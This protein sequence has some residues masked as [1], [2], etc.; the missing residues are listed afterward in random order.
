MYNTVI[1]TISG[2]Y[3]VLWTD[4]DIEKI[5][6]ELQDFQNRQGLTSPIPPLIWS[7][8]DPSVLHPVHVPPW[9]DFVQSNTHLIREFMMY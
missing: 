5:N 3:D 7:N 4:V 8:N 9:E 2:Y 1:E 6:N